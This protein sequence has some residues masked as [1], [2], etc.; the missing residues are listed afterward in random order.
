MIWTIRTEIPLLDNG[1][2]DLRIDS[3]PD[4]AAAEILAR[5]AARND[6][7]HRLE[8]LR[9]AVAERAGEVTRTLSKP[10]ERL[11][12]QI[13]QDLREVGADAAAYIAHLDRSLRSRVFTYGPKLARS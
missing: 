3:A 6:P 2:L 12:A 1:R 7:A 4:P 8:T 9:A 10:V 11:R 5:M 13:I